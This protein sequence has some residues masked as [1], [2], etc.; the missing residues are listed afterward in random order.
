M[1]REVLTGVEYGEA[2][3]R[4]VRGLG[5]KKTIRSRT[6]KPYGKKEEP[7]VS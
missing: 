3:T 1:Y 7:T 5:D 4:T 6:E 2:V